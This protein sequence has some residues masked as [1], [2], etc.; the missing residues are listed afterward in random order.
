VLP[1]VDLS[2]D[3]PVVADDELLSIPD[4]LD[5]EVVGVLPVVLLPLVLC[6]NAAGA[7]TASASAAMENSFIECLLRVR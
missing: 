6:A 4:E 3:E 1:V 2:A 7:A 5:D